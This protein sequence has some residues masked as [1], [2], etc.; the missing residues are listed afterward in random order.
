MRTDDHTTD[1]SLITVHA[2]GSGETVGDALAEA[3]AKAGEAW[4]D[5]PWITVRQTRH[6][7]SGD[8]WRV[9][10]ETVAARLPVGLQ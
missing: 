1:P 8:S 6:G 5:E 7:S 10:L 3:C 2:H 9:H 4:G